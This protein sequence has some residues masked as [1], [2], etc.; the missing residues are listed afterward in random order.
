MCLH[1]FLRTR[2]FFR[3]VTVAKDLMIGMS[4]EYRCAQGLPDFRGLPATRLE[5]HDE[6][7][8][9]VKSGVP[10]ADGGPGGGGGWVEVHRANAFDRGMF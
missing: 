2:F 10:L 1:S 7:K 3:F 5:N 9:W 8:R 6:V 4:A